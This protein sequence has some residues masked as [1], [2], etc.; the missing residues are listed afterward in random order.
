MS[1]RLQQALARANASDPAS[2]RELC[3]M[4]TR[5]GY[6]STP[7]RLAG[8]DYEQRTRLLLDVLLDVADGT[9]RLECVVTHQA[10]DVDFITRDGW[11]IRCFYDA[12][13][14]DYVDG[15]EDPDGTKWSL[16]DDPPG[17]DWMQTSG[18]QRFLVDINR[19][20]ETLP[21][22]NHA[23]A[24][25]V[26]FAWGGGLDGDGPRGV[27]WADVLA[28]KHPK[29]QRRDRDREAAPTRAVM[30]SVLE[31][32]RALGELFR[33]SQAPVAVPAP[34]PGW[35]IGVAG[36]PQQ[37]GPTITLRPYSYP[38]QPYRVTLDAEQ[39]TDE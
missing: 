31:Q 2:L 28:G 11:S 4:L 34:A 38:R 26:R 37:H 15:V 6:G 35:S 10:C 12:G 7:R 32:V 13:E 9:D 24:F 19:R 39:L 5:E 20:I 18:I 3:A 27:G 29:P 16:Y 17:G 21:V 23:I 8:L 30:Q 25:G 1:D 14:F 36:D 33:S 22:W